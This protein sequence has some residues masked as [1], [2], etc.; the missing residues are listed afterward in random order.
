MSLPRSHRTRVA[1]ALVIGFLIASAAGVSAQMGLVS[2]DVDPGFAAEPEEIEAFQL[3]QSNAYIEAREKAQ[4]ILKANPKSFVAHY[5]LGIVQEDAEANFPRA[6]FE[7]Q[8]ALRLFEARYGATP[9]PTLPWRWHARLLISIGRVH[10]DLDQY[11]QYLA[12]IARYNSIYRPEIV[13]ERAWPLMKMGRYDEAREVAGRALAM[14]SPWQES[15]AL[16]ALCAI[17]F[18]A[19]RD[20]A[21]YDVCKRALDASRERGDDITIELTNFAEA[22]RSLFKL[23]EAEEVALE[24]TKQSVSPFG[25]PWMD[26]A[27]LYTREARYSEALNAL[28]QIPHYREARPPSVRD[29]DRNETRRALASFF[30]VIGRAKDALNITRRALALPDRRSHNSR[31]P[32]QD[33]AIIALLDRRASRLAAQIVVEDAVGKPFWAVIQAQFIAA[34][35]RYEGWTSGR[36]A[37]RMLDDDARLIGSFKIGTSKAAVVPPWLI[38][39]LAQVIGPGVVLAAIEKARATDVRPGVAGY[40]D[41]FAA[42]AHWVNG[43]EADALAAAKRSLA[44]LQ[45]SESLLRARSAAIA[46]ECARELHRPKEAATF[47]DLAFQID[48]GIFR[49]LDL[50]IPVRLPDT[51]APVLDDLVNMLNNN[52][53]LSFTHESLLSIRVDGDRVSAKACLLSSGGTVLGCGEARTSGHDDAHELARKV[54]AN[55]FAEAFAPRLNLS[56][57]DANS[58]DGSNFVPHEPLK[59]ILDTTGV[60]GDDSSGE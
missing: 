60:D 10:N 24:A 49:R 55:F 21:S 52:P 12:Y 15:I 14:A 5:V 30:V 26:L 56:Q 31:D 46:A 11:S 42:E 34:G 44:A 58:L 27:E 19:G 50:A 38:G 47:Y 45:D 33:R 20:G 22:S 39:E 53:R 41:A 3:A 36:E 23:D 2:G 6:L 48:P 40:Y 35:L 16:T 57:S 54:A 9:D 18:E 13:G 32:A 4:K 7:M 8:T 29:S 59:T 17:E 28:K 37:A 51:H 43:D 1:L 25:N